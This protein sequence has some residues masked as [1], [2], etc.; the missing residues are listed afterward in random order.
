MYCENLKIV[1]YIHVC[2]CNNEDTT[3]YDCIPYIAHYTKYKDMYTTK[4]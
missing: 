3:N 1:V 2:S 4:P